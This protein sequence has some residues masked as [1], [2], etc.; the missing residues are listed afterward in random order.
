MQSANVLSI[1]LICPVG[2]DKFLFNGKKSFWGRIL[3]RREKNEERI[4]YAG[5]LHPQH[6][7]QPE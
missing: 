4:T 7:D 1:Q 3:S 2:Q 6:E 5:E